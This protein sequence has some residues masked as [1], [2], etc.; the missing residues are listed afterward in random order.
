MSFLLGLSTRTQAALALA[1]LVTAVVL[2]LLAGF[3]EP[4][5]GRWRIFRG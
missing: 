2:A 3:V 1:V 5:E 4:I